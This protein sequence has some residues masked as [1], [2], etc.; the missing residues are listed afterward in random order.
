MLCFVV[1]NIFFVGDRIV[2]HVFEFVG[3]EVDD[4]LDGQLLAILLFKFV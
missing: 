4:L 2:V 1:R 3:C